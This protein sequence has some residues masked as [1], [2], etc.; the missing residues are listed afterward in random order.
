MAE[1]E[2]EGRGPASAGALGGGMTDGAARTAMAGLRARGLVTR[3]DGPNPLGQGF[4]TWGTP[5]RLTPLGRA[6]VQ[7]IAP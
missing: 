3:T 6:A 4:S 2:R 7:E 5:W 1:R